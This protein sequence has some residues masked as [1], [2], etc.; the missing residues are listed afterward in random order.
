MLGRIDI[1]GLAGQRVGLAFEFEQTGAKFVTLLRE[2]RGIDQYA[3]AFHMKE[4]VARRN[5]D[6]AVNM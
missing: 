6:R 3:G 4:N 1:E 2:Q 5:F